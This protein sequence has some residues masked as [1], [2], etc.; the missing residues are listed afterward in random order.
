MSELVSCYSGTRYA[1]RPTAFRF[2]DQ[3]LAVSQVLRQWREPDSLHFV[4]LVP[5]GRHFQLSLCT[6]SGHW[7]VDPVK[8]N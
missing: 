7:R 2:D 3:Q 8:D 1:E 4:V 6:H 5:D